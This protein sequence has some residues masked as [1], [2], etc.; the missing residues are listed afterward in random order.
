MHTKAKQARRKC[1]VGRQGRIWKSYLLPPKATSWKEKGI[2]R[3][4]FVPEALSAPGWRKLF[5]APGL[6]R[7]GKA[8]HRQRKNPGQKPPLIFYFLLYEK[9]CPKKHSSPLIIS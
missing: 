4:P 3:G 2:G 8:L 9:K 6:L 5:S 7:H 1:D